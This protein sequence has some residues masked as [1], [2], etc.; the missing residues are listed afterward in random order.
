MISVTS[1]PI[2]V[3]HSIAYVLLYVL[4]TDNHNVKTSDAQIQVIDSK[5]KHVGKNSVGTV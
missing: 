1:K 2:L 5:M 4:P 3:V